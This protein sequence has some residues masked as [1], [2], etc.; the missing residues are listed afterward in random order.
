MCLRFYRIFLGLDHVLY[1]VRSDQVVL[2]TAIILTN[3]YAVGIFGQKKDR[4]LSKT[5]PALSPYSSA[6]VLNIML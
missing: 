4:L 3:S 5:F 6:N 2:C 1:N